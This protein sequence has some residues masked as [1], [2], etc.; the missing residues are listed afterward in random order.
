VKVDGKT[1]V[2]V[3]GTFGKAYTAAVKHNRER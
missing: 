2:L 1:T 3:E